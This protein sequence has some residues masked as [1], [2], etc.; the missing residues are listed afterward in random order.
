MKK[1]ILF[2]IAFVTVFF[3]PSILL[4]LLF[5]FWH[6]VNVEIINDNTESL[7]MWTNSEAQYKFFNNLLLKYE[8]EFNKKVNSDYT[9]N[10]EKF[11]NKNTTEKT[12]NLYTKQGSNYIIKFNNK[13]YMLS[14]KETDK[15]N[16]ILY[17]DYD[18]VDVAHSISGIDK[19]VLKDSTLLCY[20]YYYGG[21]HGDGQ[22][23]VK[24][25]LD[26][27]TFT[28]LK[29]DFSKNWNKIPK[30][31]DSDYDD[32]STFVR[33]NNNCSN[34]D[35]VTNGIYYVRNRFDSEYG[36]NIFQNYDFMVLDYDENIIYITK[37]D[38]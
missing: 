6:D 18:Y 1:I 25:K 38:L 13:F 31:E 17:K 21:F 33:L 11:G 35:L 26:N 2:F 7:Y 14:K 36:E 8:I 5:Y 24:L 16:S 30:E 15:A 22:A 27:K 12:L 20:V 34:I 32:Y 28:D 29:N 3:L 19:K 4:M 37:T 10:L 9:I 23:A